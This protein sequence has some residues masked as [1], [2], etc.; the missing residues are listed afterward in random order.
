MGLISR[1]TC[2][3]A[4]GL[5]LAALPS[6]RAAQDVKAAA[7][8]K[9]IDP[10]QIEAPVVDAKQ[11]KASDDMKKPAWLTEL[12]VTTKEI[13]DSNVFGADVNRAATFPKIANV[14]SWMTSV[15]PKVSINFAPLLD[16]DKG[17]KTVETFALSYAPEVVRY[18]DAATENYEA[19]RI[20][21]Q[22]K[23]TV[24]SFSYNLDNAVTVIDG[25]RNSPQYNT[26]SAYGSAIARERRDQ[27]QERGKLVLRND[28][29]NWFV[30]GVA[31][32]AYYD[33]NSLT[34]DNSA[35][36][37]HPGWQNWVDR[38][39]V[40]GGMDIGYK[41]TKD[42]AATL[43]Y[44]HGY[45]YQQNFNWSAGAPANS[46]SYDR[47]LVGVEGKP[48]KWLKIEV[49]GGPS[50]HSY[51]QNITAAG[52]ANDIT[53]FFCEGAA[54]AQIT[55][56]DSIL[57]NIKQW[58]WVSST[59]V[60]SYED[61]TYGVAYKRQWFKQ[62]SSTVGMTILDSHYNAPMVR[63]DWL[64]IY[65]VGLKYDLNEHFALTADYSYS[66][67]ENGVDEASANGREFERNLV[68][69]GVKAA[70]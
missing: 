24:D 50:F 16:Q 36:S 1:R 54:T 2:C 43:G 10:K 7:D 64:Y 69:L 11:V 9:Q 49:Q 33:L 42:F 8:P 21:T 35:T 20:G 25:N 18:Y 12:S 53:Q 23:G 37:A 60:S 63:D 31:T 29:E 44:R 32:T 45:Q 41:I 58:Q 48:T 19:H 26:V 4:L 6:L 27:M 46:N 55:A 67:G 65:N 15:T 38:Y 47:A 66:R 57:L 61:K 40:N 68:S 14:S 30:R 13:Y 59:G 62:F 17:D 34:Y 22:L 3:A 39:D 52:H 56:D 28:W 5:I 51:D 70:F